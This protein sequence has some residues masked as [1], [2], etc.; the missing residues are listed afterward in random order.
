M[1][2]PLSKTA[3]WDIDFDTIDETTHADF[4][5]ARVFQYGLLNDLRIVLKNF[6]ATQITHALTNQ[7]GLDKIT[8]DFAK[9]LGYISQ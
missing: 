9:T 2:L 3:F 4:I 1:K 8:I 7:R 5:I 6:S